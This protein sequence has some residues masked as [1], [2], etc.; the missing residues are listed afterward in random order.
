MDAGSDHQYGLRVAANRIKALEILRD[1]GVDIRAVRDRDVIVATKHTA[2]LPLRFVENDG[3]QQPSPSRSGRAWRSGG[4]RQL[5]VVHR[6][7]DELKKEARDLQI[8]LVVISERSCI[9][10][11]HELP[12]PPRAIGGEGF[13]ICALAR[14]LLSTHAP[15]R[16]GPRLGSSRAR[17]A[18]AA[19]LAESLG[20]GQSRVSSLMNRLVKEL[21]KD[22]VQSGRGGCSVTDFDKL[23][24]WHLSA[25]PGPWG[26]TIELQHTRGRPMQ[27]RQGNQTLK[28]ASGLIA[29][30]RRASQ[31]H[32]EPMTSG[33]EALPLWQHAE[34]IFESARLGGNSP[35]TILSET[36]GM[37]PADDRY[38]RCQPWESSIRLA[39]IADP[40]LRVTARA[41]GDAGKTDPVVTAW[42]IEGE[43]TRLDL[44]EW[45]K[46]RRAEEPRLIAGAAV[47]R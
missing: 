14:L 33:I 23:W 7:T 15:W 32:N 45:S 46:S 28:N 39:Q 35:V 19:S 43:R 34:A 4:A 6:A 13:L 2:N 17:T 31:D 38:L 12:P 11:G 25:Y 41:W 44:R 42:V 18:E 21:P 1:N 10:N 9:I 30:Q 8:D 47:R 29:S 24:D 27:L 40:H 16:Q 3:G 37:M 26:A 5:H 36:L 22:A 20:V